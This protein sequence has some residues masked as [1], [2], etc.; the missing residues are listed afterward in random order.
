MKQLD[1][2]EPIYKYL[3]E[4]IS[5]L[6]YWVF[7]RGGSRLKCSLPCAAVGRFSCYYRCLF[8][9]VDAQGK[10]TCV[11]FLRTVQRLLKSLQSCNGDRGRPW[12]LYIEISFPISVSFLSICNEF[13]VA[14][15][16]EHFPNRGKYLVT[17]RD[18]VLSAELCST[19]RNNE[20][21]DS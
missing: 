6:H 13:L 19:Q 12:Y 9:S 17:R 2:I 10:Q 3:A 21:L 20:F 15:K 4:G 14:N 7:Q 5:Q 11:L 16:K 8:L 1:T 18:W